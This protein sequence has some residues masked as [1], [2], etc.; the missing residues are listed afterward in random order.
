M[1]ERKPGAQPGNRNALK[2]G[3]YSR[4]F[5]PSETEAVEAASIEGLHNEIIMLRVMIRRVVELATDPESD[6][7][8]ESA[9]AALNT[10]GNATTRLARLLGAEKKLALDQSK[11][12]EALNQALGEVIAELR[13]KT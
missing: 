6:T 7:S 5:K 12:P 1:A 10:L 13:G 9:I 8:L 2:H 4:N 3:F 11:S